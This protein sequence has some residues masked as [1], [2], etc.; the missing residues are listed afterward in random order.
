MDSLTKTSG[1]AVSVLAAA[2]ASVLLLLPAR[3]GGRTPQVLSTSAGVLVA[4]AAARAP[5]SPRTLTGTARPGGAPAQPGQVRGATGEGTRGARVVPAWRDRCRRG[6]PAPG[7][8]RRAGASTAAGRGHSRGLPG[9]CH[10]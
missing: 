1:V 6:T 9:L 10:G 3:P 4:S 2:T 5:A 8:L 7:R